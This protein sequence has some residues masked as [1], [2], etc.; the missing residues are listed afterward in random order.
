VEFNETIAVSVYVQTFGMDGVAKAGVSAF[1]K[2]GATRFETHVGTGIN[3]AESGGSGRKGDA[4]CQGGAILRSGVINS[5][6]VAGGGGRV[7]VVRMKLCVQ[8]AT[9]PKL[10]IRRGEGGCGRPGVRPVL[11][12]NEDRLQDTDDARY[13]RVEVVV[14]VGGCCTPGKRA[15]RLP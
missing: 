5:M 11:G 3:K 4:P 13:L 7:G 14:H 6:A 10:F 2:G 12:V 9:E 8:H 15:T 1:K